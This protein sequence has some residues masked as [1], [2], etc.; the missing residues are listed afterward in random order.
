MERDNTTVGEES[1]AADGWTFMAPNTADIGTRGSVTEGREN[2]TRFPVA[3]KALRMR[4][5]LSR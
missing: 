3:E 5:M 2:Y 4:K 1:V